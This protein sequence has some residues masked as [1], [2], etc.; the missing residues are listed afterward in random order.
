M[1]VAFF[2]R[3]VTLDYFKEYYI[4]YLVSVAAD[5]LIRRKDYV[6]NCWLYWRK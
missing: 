6:W 2:C 4:M 5:G 1:I 3:Q